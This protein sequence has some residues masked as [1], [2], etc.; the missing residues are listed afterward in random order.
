MC[1]D[2]AGTGGGIEGGVEDARISSDGGRVVGGA[3]RSMAELTLTWLE[4]EG[5][6]LGVGS[7]WGSGDPQ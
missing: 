4:E 1:L 6:D 3:A 2:L 7:R 5:V